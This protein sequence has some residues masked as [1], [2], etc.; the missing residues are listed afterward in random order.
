MPFRQRYLPIKQCITRNC[1]NW[2]YLSSKARKRC[3]ECIINRRGIKEL[4]K[5]KE[6]YKKHDNKTMSTLYE[7]GSDSRV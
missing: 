2:F 3:N 1:G 7:G 6:V 5:E 4:L